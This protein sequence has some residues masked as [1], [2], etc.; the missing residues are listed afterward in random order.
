MLLQLGPRLRLDHVPKMPESIQAC[1]MSSP[2]GSVGT[3]ETP[4]ELLMMLGRLDA[5]GFSPS[6]S[7]GSSIHSI[8][9]RKRSK[10]PCEIAFDAIH[11]APGATP[12]WFA[13]PSLPTIVP[14]VCV[15]WSCSSCGNSESPKTS[16]QL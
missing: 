7:S 6:R 4:H 16:N 11:R 10:S 8:A 3:P 15:P 5:S 2:N 13:P 14:I 1:W 9:S 12:I